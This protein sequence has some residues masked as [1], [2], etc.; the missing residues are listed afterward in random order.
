MKIS[1]FLVFLLVILGG[2]ISGCKPRDEKI[3]STVERKLQQHQDLILVSASVD[4][5]I[6]TLDGAVNTDS[7]RNIAATIAD[8][9]NGTSPIVNRIRLNNPS[10]LSSESIKDEILTEEMVQILKDYPGVS[11]KVNDGIITLTGHISAKQ[12]HNLIDAIKTLYPTDIR[13]QMMVK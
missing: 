12:E 3:K 1:G 9:S 13:D 4:K 7:E 10:S 11:E 2:M 6:V 8:E 5:G